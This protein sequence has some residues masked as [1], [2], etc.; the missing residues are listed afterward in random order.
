MNNESNNERNLK[1]SVR[2]IPSILSKNRTVIAVVAFLYLIP[3]GTTASFSPVRT[4]LFIITQIMIFG[5]LAMSFDLQLGRASLLNFGHVALF[6]VGAYFM[7][8]TLDAGLLPPPFNLIATIPYPF[9]L[10]FAMLI[11][12]GLGL[13]MGLTTSRM[14]GTAFAFIA[15]AIAMF[16]FNFFR[17]NPDISG[18]ETGLQVPTP[19]I[20]R[21]GPFYLLFVAIAFVFLAAFIGTVILYIKKRTDYTGLI[22]LTPVMVAF[23]G[24][25][26]IFGTNILGP[27]LVFIAFL[28]MILLNR[29]ERNKSLSDPLREN[30]TLTGEVKSTN[31]LTAYVLPFIIM[32]VVLV[33]LVLSFAT[34]I[35]D[36]V[37]LWIEDS[38]LYY[39]TIPVQFYLVLTCLVITYAF[40]RRL[41]ASPFGRMITAVAQ[42]EERAEALGYNSY[43]AKIVVLVISGAIA[44]LAGAL[45]APFIRIIVP[46]T[47]LGVEVTINAMLYT[48]IGGIATLLGPLLGT[49]VVVYSELNLVSLIEGFGLPGR[50]W[51][52]ALGVLYIG[53][54]L[55]MPLG[56]VGSIGRRVDSLK[57]S[58][59]QMK[60]RQFEFGL[61]DADY[62]IFGLLGTMGLV[63][64]L[65]EDPRF[66]PISYGIFG[67]LGAVGFLL[68]LLFRRE[69]ASRIKGVIRRRRL[70]RRKIGRFEFGPKY[71][72]YVLFGSLGTL[73]ILLLLTEDPRFLL[74]SYGIFGFLG[75]L[76]LL[77]MILYRM[78]IASRIRAFIKSIR[79]RLAKGGD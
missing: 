65:S 64:L 12:G 9:T 47:V 72:D 35:A 37:S 79:M 16:I 20:I 73:G 56:I 60:V 26:L 67:F 42:N 74:I 69:I 78:E 40:I 44:S 22:L 3:L 10:L 66:L 58:F 36:M 77:L 25:L 52:I 7:A 23:T 6:G 21:T 18:G 41:I 68:M 46:D 45:Y 17:Q 71:V 63:L 75:A 14:R 57:G 13:I 8:Y 62:W 11:G 49:G 19:D 32:I 4:L 28:G 70:R 76:G 55:F 51:L 38:S 59:R 24:V 31:K 54:V 27:V 5:L 50:L 53:I 34:N 43:H 29:F 15:L 61:K 39:F 2:G 48:I 30:Q 1:R 33:G